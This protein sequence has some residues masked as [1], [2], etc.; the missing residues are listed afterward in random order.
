MSPLGS[1]DSRDSRD[2]LQKHRVPTANLTTAETVLDYISPDV[3]LSAKA[4]A[5]GVPGV[6]PETVL[7]HLDTLLLRGL[8]MRDQKGNYLRK[9]AA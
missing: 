5:Q 4:V 1:L 8:V 9:V 7:S 3:A 2:T 6:D